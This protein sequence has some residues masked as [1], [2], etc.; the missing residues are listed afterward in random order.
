MIIII[1]I[2]III[3]IIIIIVIIKIMSNNAPQF[4]SNF[5]IF[6]LRFSNFFVDSIIKDCL[7]H[8]YSVLQVIEEN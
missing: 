6:V 4:I 5:L 7:K 1:I 2:M 8:I 3:M